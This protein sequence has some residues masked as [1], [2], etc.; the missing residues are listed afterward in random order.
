MTLHNYPSFFLIKCYIMLQCGWV[1]E[2]QQH[3]I[4]R[5]CWSLSYN[6]SITQHENNRYTESFI[7]FWW[8]CELLV[9]RTTVNGLEIEEMLMIWHYYHCYYTNLRRHTH[10]IMETNWLDFWR[11][12]RKLCQLELSYNPEK[13]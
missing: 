13:E 3:V 12:L 9:M 8:W 10:V 7:N 6:T 11:L 1:W 5:Y 2:Q 4:D